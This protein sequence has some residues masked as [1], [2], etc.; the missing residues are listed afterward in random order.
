MDASLPDTGE[1]IKFY[2]L[3][4]A[5]IIRTYPEEKIK[6]DLAQTM[7]EIRM[8]L[9][10]AIT[11]IITSYGFVDA[12]E[13][14][15]YGNTIV[16]INIPYCLH[17]PNGVELDIN[18]PEKNL[19]AR[20]LCRKIWTSKAAGSSITDIYAE[21]KTIYFNNGDV[22]TPKLPVD[23]LLGWQPDLTGKNV[24]RIKDNNGHFRF[25]QL[26]ILLKTGYTKKQ[27]GNK[28]GLDKI[29][30]EIGERAIEIVNR[31][32]DVYRYITK[33]EFVERLGSINITNIYLYEHNFGIYPVTMNTQSAVM[34]RSKQETEKIA[35][36]L[37]NGGKPPLYELLLLNARSSLDKRMFNLSIVSSFQGLEI[38]LENFFIDKY[39]RQNMTQIDIK[40]KLDRVWKTKERLRDL[41]KE[42]TGHSLL[43]NRILW[44]QWC[45]AYDEIRNE[46]IHRG[47]EI[48]QSAT[49]KTLKLNQDVIDWIKSLH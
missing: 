49:E 33:E 40:A 2:L 42:T 27:L 39:T 8:E 25:T 11:R 36:M 31:L 37:K 19:Q 35:E 22:I 9:P 38:F 18:I 17:I 13:E 24:E 32:L 34:N 46:V 45:T 16:E 41:L 26:Q 20:V 7:K 29:S 12:P 30:S 6:A 28:S 14:I 44:D 43:E 4:N 15:D 48:D 10:M 47:K 21:D 23:L 5:D 3:A 1:R